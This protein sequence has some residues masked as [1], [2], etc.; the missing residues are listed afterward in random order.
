MITVNNGEDLKKAIEAGNKII[1]VNDEAL[2]NKIK[3]IMKIPSAKWTAVIGVAATGIASAI[4]ALHPF[5]PVDAVAPHVSGPLR[6]A[7]GTVV[8][9]SGAQI[10]AS[11]G[12]PTALALVTV[13]VAVGGVAIIKNLYS[14]Y[15]ISEE[16]SNYVILKKK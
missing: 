12:F 11:V 4:A 6:G 15:E 1:R 9:A 2:A 10:T 16:G 7:A 14:N 5:T 8:I 3:L 13:G